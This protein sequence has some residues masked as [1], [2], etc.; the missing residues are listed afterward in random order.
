MKALL[1]TSIAGDD[2]G[3]SL[4]RR[5]EVAAFFAEVDPRTA[6][7]RRRQHLCGDQHEERRHPAIL[8]SA[9]AADPE[10]ATLLADYTE[11]RDQGQG[12]I[13][14]SLARDDALR[15]DL[16]ER[17]ADVIH[18]L[19]S[20]ELYRL[21]VV[22]RGWSPQRYQRWPTSATCRPSPGRQ[23]RASRGLVRRL[24]SGDH[25][26]DPV[27]R[28]LPGGDVGPVEGVDRRDGDQSRTSEAS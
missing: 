12:L 18:A 3:I 17:D 16:K 8:C 20:P 4:Q 25:L 27:P 11:L 19:M 2:Q 1:D 24:G 9:A 21:L 26:A 28:D 5:P 15:R 6:R 13:A 7:R 23:A 10:A 14:A 22:D